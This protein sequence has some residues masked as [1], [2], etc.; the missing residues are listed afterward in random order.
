[1]KKVV[2][3]PAAQSVVACKSDQQVITCPAIEQVITKA[4][5]QHI[6]AAPAKK[7]FILKCADDLIGRI[8]ANTNSGT[9]LKLKPLD[10]IANL[11]ID[12]GDYGVEPFTR[13]LDQGLPG[14]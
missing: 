7:L 14:M 8:A 9:A 6:I 3:I 1:M 13:S 11:G 5:V 10:V 4:C 12:K 2:S